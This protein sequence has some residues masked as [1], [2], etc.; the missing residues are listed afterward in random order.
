MLQHRDMKH[1]VHVPLYITNKK[2]N[3]CFVSPTSSFARR[4]DSLE[5]IDAA[6]FILKNKTSQFSA[7][8]Q[9]TVVR[10]Y[11]ENNLRSMPFGSNTRVNKS[12]H[13]IEWTACYSLILRYISN[14]RQR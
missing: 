13:A 9:V 7:P 11:I 14:K 1:L 4:T 8:Q 5:I 6:K 2:K 12:N 10:P 3:M